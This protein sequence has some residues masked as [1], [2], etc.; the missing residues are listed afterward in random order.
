MAIKKKDKIIGVKE[1]EIPQELKLVPNWVLWRAEW[2]EKQQNYGKVPYSI[3]GYRA[4]TTNEKTWCDFESVSIEYAVD[5]Q[6]NGIGFVL[7]DDNNFVCLDIDNVIDEKGQINSELALKMMQ[8]TYCEK[9]PSGT[10]LHCFFKGKL[11][12]NRKKK[13]TDLDIELY[14]SARFMTVTG[15]AI[16]QNNIC[17]D[18]EI[19]NNLVEDYFK[20][21]L[22]VNDVAREESNT[23][24]QSSDEDIINVMMKS[25]QKDKIKDLLQGTYESYFESSSEAVQSLLHYLAFY[26]GKNKQQ[27]E[28]IFLNYNNLTD[29]WESKRGNTTWGQ[30]E[31]DKAIKNQKTV[32][33]KSIDEFDVIVEKE[34]EK[35][36]LKRLGNEERVY[37]EQLWIEEGSKGRKPTV[38]SPNRC[39]HL[40]KENLNFIL[41]DLE[42]NTKLAMYRAE[43]GIYTQNISYI[44]RVISWLEP[45][46]NSNKADE[47]IYHLKNRVDIKSKTNS[48]VLIPVKNGV[49][50]RKTKQLESFTPE[51][52]FTTKINTAYK[53]QSVVPIIEGWSVDNWINE[54][55][56]NDHGVAKLLW[57]VIND[58]LNG[59]YTRKKAIFLVGDGNNGKG[60]FQELISQVIG[61]ENI[62][63]LKVNEFDE[64]FKLSVLEGKT[65]V[66]GDDVPVGVY[67]D[68]SS[69][70]KSVV[71]GDP[72][73]VEFKNQ[74][75]YR[76]TFKC[77]VIQSTNGMPS[78][79]DKT[80][81]TLRRLLIVPFKA[82]FNGQSDNSKIKEQ[83]VKN[84]KVLEYVLYK[85]I[86]MDFDIFDIPDVSK[87]MLE[88]F[89]EDNDPVYGFKVNMFDQWTVRKVP[90]Y[91]VYAFY[92]EY[93]D[94]NGYNSLSSNKF[95]KQ[96]EHYLEAYWKINAQRRYDNEELAKRIYNF[97]DNRNYIE[98]I[99]SGKNYKS[100]EKENLKAI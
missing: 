7:S 42:E 23:N 25:K 71:T 48:P 56:C 32:Y 52:V 24:M 2:N 49:F 40:L 26:T 29:K 55:A 58:S 41:F 74:P 43:E 57:Q 78:F 88:V 19:L 95:Y 50:N 4:S 54:I 60:T 1:L 73:L 35:D 47:V 96:F 89:K 37:M 86:N 91:I 53:T 92:K 33:T 22:S 72:V 46:L 63:S 97:N 59:N 64:R 75:L 18:Q 31:L 13:R 84:K 94:E 39:A 82:N 68:D 85:A 11:P 6:Y 90:K 9:S 30:L 69:N 28:R 20:E 14:D 67:V 10:G 65:A 81:G 66:I 77:T 27:M 44:K 99:E 70:F 80:S 3:N 5:E 21:N 15:C 51:Y 17:D 79:K 38:I 45:K 93:C 34:T 36:K 61:E 76:A 98:P 100:Y 83:Y 62:A 87:K 16:G 8:F 12:D